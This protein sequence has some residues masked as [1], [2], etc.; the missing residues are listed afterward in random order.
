MGEYLILAYIRNKILDL[1]ELQCCAKLLSHPSFYY[2]LLPRG[3][4]FLCFLK[5]VFSNS[6][7]LDIGCFFTHFSLVSPVV[8]PLMLG[9]KE[10][11]NW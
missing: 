2:I 9:C 4:I 1:Y 7:S 11:V 10:E 5:V 8:V 6:F 3:Q